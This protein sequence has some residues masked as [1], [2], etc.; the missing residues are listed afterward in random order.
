MR[1]PVSEASLSLG[2]FPQA[3][4]GEG[5]YGLDRT[6]SGITSLAHSKSAQYTPSAKPNSE[7]FFDRKRPVD[8]QTCLWPADGFVGRTTEQEGVRPRREQAW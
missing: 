2:D 6:M 5:L 1:F 4:T 7:F 3:F 8:T